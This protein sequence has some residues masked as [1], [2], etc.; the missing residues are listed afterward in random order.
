MGASGGAAAGLYLIG[1]YGMKPEGEPDQQVSPPRF[2]L[3]R[4]QIVNG[5]L[6][7]GIKYAVRRPGDR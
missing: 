1:R 3:V 4:A 5:A 2:D 7:Y 6:T